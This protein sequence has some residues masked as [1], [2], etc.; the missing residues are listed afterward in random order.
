MLFIPSSKAKDSPS[1]H[2]QDHAGFEKATPVVYT[3]HATLPVLS[4]DQPFRAHESGTE[5]ALPPPMLTLGVGSSRTTAH[6]G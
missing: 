3:H 5:P 6:A 4:L 2:G 1:P